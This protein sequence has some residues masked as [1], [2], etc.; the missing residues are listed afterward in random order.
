[1]CGLTY[2][3]ITFHASLQG[4]KG[5]KV[6]FPTLEKYWEKGNHG[7]DKE[8]EKGTPPHVIIPLMGQFKGEQGEQCH[9]LPLA[10]ESKSGIQIRATLRLMR[11]IRE[12]LKIT[13][14]WLFCNLAGNKLRFDKM[15]DI[16][17]DV[18][19]SVKE[20]DTDNKLELNEINIK[21]N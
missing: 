21:R 1:M 3:M 10:M 8:K 2:T 13:S 6:Y 4:S 11:Q 14:A 12:E 19:E 17:L 9:L 5:L 15:N 18:I 7:Y 16:I 20:R